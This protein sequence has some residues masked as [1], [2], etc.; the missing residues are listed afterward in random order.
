MRAA[1]FVGLALIAFSSTASP[2]TILQTD[3]QGQRQVIQSQAIVVRDDSFALAYKHF[4]LK[5][6]R[7]EKV[8]LDQGSLPYQVVQASAA[9]RKQIVKLWKQFGFTASVTDQAGKKTTVYDVYLDFFPPSGGVFL[10][11]VPARTNLPILLAAGGADQV[12]FSDIASIQVRGGKL[13]VILTNGRT[14]TGTLIPP[15]NRPAIPHLMGITDHYQPGSAN[16]YDF[17]LP[18]AQ[19]R[20][21][22]F[23]GN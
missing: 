21:I 1:L 11:S 22:R 4:D 14:E 23:Q 5:Q 12:D 9:Q 6:R 2:D 17:S 18:L 16:V 3:A 19:I 15:T 7:I 20:E 8:Q 10:E 13:T